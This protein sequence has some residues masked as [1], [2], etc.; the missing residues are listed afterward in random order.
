MARTTAS[1]MKD[2]AEPSG[3]LKACVN[4][5]SMTVPIVTPTLPVG[6]AVPERRGSRSSLENRVI[7]AMELLEDVQRELTAIRE[8]LR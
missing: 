3:Q 1:I 6:T 8:A 2:S 5:S 7:R 4:W